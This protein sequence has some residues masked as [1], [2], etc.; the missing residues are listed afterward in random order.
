MIN[1]NGIEPKVLAWDRAST[2]SITQSFLNLKNGDV[3]IVRI[4]IKAGWGVGMK[5]NAKAFIR[6][7][8][9][10]S[11]WLIMNR[12]SYDCIHAC[13]LHTILPALIP[14]VIF[15][16]KLV[17][18]VF[19]YFADTAHGS[20]TVRK[21]G[22]VFETWVINHADAVI[23]CSEQR[24]Q[25]ISP[26][27]PQRLFVIENS[28]AQ[29]QFSEIDHENFPSDSHPR[30]TRMV[31]V[32]NLVEDRCI[33]LM[34]DTVELIPNLELHIGGIGALSTMVA[35]RAR[36]SKN[37][38]W[39]GK[40]SYQDVLRLEASC[41]LMIALYDPAIPN[42]RYAA[43]NKFYEALALGKPII[44][45]RNT[46][47]DKIIADHDLGAVVEKSQSSLLN[48]INEL[49][50]NRD[51]WNAMGRRGRTLYKNAFSWEI[52]EERLT[53]LY[54]QIAIKE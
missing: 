12:K 13:D 18:D 21:L 16:K 4:G 37:I 31:Y 34:L 28:P 10:S 7:V 39:Y 8:V 9:L 35:E 19:D 3:P 36:N 26:A 20:A 49:I 15:R 14:W 2:H 6:Y 45:F 48:G 5:N 1:I 40:M 51:A 54:E 50:M 27:N 24:R 41:D 46:G 11:K 42:H 43:P 30:K 22:R 23:I 44:M 52:M 29:S 32:G 38:F 53:A 25:Q 17:Y 33:S 47:V